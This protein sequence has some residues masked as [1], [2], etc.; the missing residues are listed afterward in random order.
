[1]EELLT[2]E[3][4]ADYLRVSVSTVR[5]M[6][7]DGRL[8]GVNIG[9]QWRIPKEALAELTRPGGTD[10]QEIRNAWYLQQLA[11]LVVVETVDGK[12]GCFA[13]APFRHVDLEAL[14]PYKGYHPN[15]IESAVPVADYVLPFYG[16]RREALH[17][18]TPSMCC[19]AVGKEIFHGCNQTY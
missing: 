19:V 1:M 2:I 12:L 11:N 13:V 9:R 17:R 18:G 10:K 16:L 3:E 5:R 15:E 4:T 14:S 8:K 7:N 6:L